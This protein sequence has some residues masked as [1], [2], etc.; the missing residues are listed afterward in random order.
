MK[1]FTKG[2]LISGAILI[3]GF[4]CIMYGFFLEKQ[5]TYEQGLNDAFFFNN[6]VEYNTIK[7]CAHHITNDNYREE[8]VKQ[9]EQNLHWFKEETRVR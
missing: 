5:E 1:D 9:Y 4:A 6:C 2:Y 8:L 7:E 3:T